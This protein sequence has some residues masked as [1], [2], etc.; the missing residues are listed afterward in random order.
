MTV[1]RAGYP[2]VSCEIRLKDWDEGNDCKTDTPH[3]S[4]EI[5]IGRKV[6]A[7]GY[8]A[9]AAKE[10]VN[11]VEINGTR[12]EYV[13][14]TKVEMA[15]SKFPVVENCCLCASASAEYTIVLINLN[16][17]ANRSK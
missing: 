2:L 17:K 3:P 15:I 6:V 9:E 13:S 16:P 4:G 10:N 1:G 8:F 5:L 7:N 12:Y 14:L 11:F